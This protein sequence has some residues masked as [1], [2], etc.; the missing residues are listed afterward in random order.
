MS[1]ELG[2]I[3]ARG[4]VGKELVELVG[5]NPGLTLALAISQ[6]DG[7]SP[8]DVAAKALDAYVLALPNGASVPYVAAIA[9][10]RPDALIVDLSGDHRFDD[11]WI[12]G[13]P[14]R[15]RAR[16]KTAR[17]VANPGCYATAM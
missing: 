10:T 4:Y 3:G 17:R 8:E 2:I 6:R 5:Q 9:K 13:Q 16:I 7:A 14:E 11:S 15:Q 12:Y 1:I